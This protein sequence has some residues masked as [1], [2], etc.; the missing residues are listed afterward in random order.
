M[1]TFDFNL[2]LGTPGWDTSGVLT[3]GEIVAEMDR[4]NVARG[5]ISHLAGSIHEVVEGNGLLIEALGMGDTTDRLVPVPSIDIAVADGRL[6]WDEWAALGA[7]GV[8]ACPSV[9]GRSDDAAPT[10]ALLERIAGLGW[11]LQVPLRSFCGAQWPTG[12]VAD[13]AALAG[14]NQAVTVV[15][16]CPSRQDFTVFSS[17]MKTHDNLWADV[18]NLSTG[19]GVRDLV[20]MGFAERLVCGSGFGVSYMTPMRDAVLQSPIADEARQAIVE[21]NAERLLA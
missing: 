9:F 1:K 19:T 17:A 3:T 18:G 8:R 16:I 7:K 12:T 11:H 2:T 13:A 6:D 5:L 15:M 20:E 4:C 14:M 21:A 10:E